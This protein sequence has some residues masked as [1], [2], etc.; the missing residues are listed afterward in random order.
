MRRL[1]VCCVLGLSAL[2]VVAACGG[3]GDEA[4]GPNATPQTS[5]EIEA[6]ALKFDKR[7]MTA[8]AN[9]SVTISFENR[10]SG[11]PHNVAVYRNRSAKD[12]LFVGE[13]FSGNATR[14]YRFETPEAG[15]YFFRCDTRPDTMTGTFAVR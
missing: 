8:P 11:V 5:L 15:D 6:R 1:L 14:D 9:T 4:T 10:D 13:A 7:R 3:G 12:E 2:L